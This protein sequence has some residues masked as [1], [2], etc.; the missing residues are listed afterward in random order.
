MADG[1]NGIMYKHSGSTI[2]H[3]FF[4]SLA[5]LITITMHLAIAAEGFGFHFRA[6]HY[7]RMG[8]CF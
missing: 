3:H 2:A 7:A 4:Y 8:I 1:H 5:H 6:A